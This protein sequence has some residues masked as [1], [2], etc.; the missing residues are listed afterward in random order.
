MEERLRQAYQLLRQL[1]ATANYKGFSYAA[2]ATALCAERPD[3]LLLVT[4]D[5]YPE[6]A[7]RFQTTWQAV[8]RNIRT[9]I[10]VVWAR[11]PALLSRMAGGPLEERPR[12]SQFIAIVTAGIQGDGV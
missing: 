3:L 11:N 9:V 7:K 6:V 5:L 10:M 2:Y 8:E 1:G 4:K 12:S